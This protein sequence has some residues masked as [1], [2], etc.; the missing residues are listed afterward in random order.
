[1]VLL[2]LFISFALLIVGITI[3]GN[4]IFFPRLQVNQTDEQ[5]F[6]SILIP[7]RNEAAV[8]ARTVKQVLTQTYPYFELLVLDDDSSDG[9]GAL[10]KKAAGTDE[11]FRLLRGETLPRGW[12]GKNWAC[13]QLSEAA[14]GS[15]LLFL[16]ADVL[17]LPEALATLVAM[18]S[19]DGAGLL[20]VWPSQITESWSERLV[21]PLI[22]FVI[23]GYLPVLPVHHAPCSV[24][25]A[26]NGQCLLFTHTAYEL[27][28]G[29]ATVREKILED[30]ALA[31]QVKKMGLRLRMA[32]GNRLVSCH[33]YPGGWPQVRDGFAKNLLSGHGNNLPFLL[34][35]TV[36]HWLV[37]VIPW[38]WWVFGGGWFALILG[39]T[40]VLLRGLT[41]AFSHQRILDALLMPLSVVLMTEIAFRSIA[42]HFQSR[43]TWK[44][45]SLKIED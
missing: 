5:S 30:V 4:L 33:M 44:G 35:S 28:G 34:I 3:I 29:H 37:F 19:H 42:W 32:D 14:S 15:L 12:L 13:H 36:F 2:N 20:T 31:R 17:L 45:R 8:I 23:L 16:D 25:A 43:A 27:S 40:G 26:A 11:R 41:A 9:T 38:I 18:R 21:V 10:A 39:L 22:A 24:F 1:M 6:V 7:A